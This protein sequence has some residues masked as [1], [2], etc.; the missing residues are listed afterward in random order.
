LQSTSPRP[1]VVRRLPRESTP[2]DHSLG[3]LPYSRPSPE[4]SVR[5]PSNCRMSAAR[6]SGTGAQAASANSA[7]SPVSD[8]PPLA[9]PFGRAPYVGNTTEA[10]FFRGGGEIFSG[11]GVSR[12]VPGAEDQAGDERRG[13]QI[14][15]RPLSL[16]AVPTLGRALATTL[17]H[18][19]LAARTLTRPSGMA[20][21]G[22]AGR[23]RQATRGLSSP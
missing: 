13:A 3:P 11:V 8:G 6:Y 20:S 23:D 1:R 2:L 9:Q 21:S 7:R 14:F 16:L 5:S 15:L 12:W 4:S 18:G 22:S 19:A 17:S 10:V